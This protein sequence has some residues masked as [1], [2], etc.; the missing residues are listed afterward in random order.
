M[1]YIC[2]FLRDSLNEENPPVYIPHKEETFTS[3]IERIIET[4]G[5]QGREIKDV[6]GVVLKLGTFGLPIMKI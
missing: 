3:F 2:V 4:E 5:E 1:S 6:N